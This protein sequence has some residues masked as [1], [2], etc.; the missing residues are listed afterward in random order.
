MN[1]L[2]LEHLAAV[3]KIAACRQAREHQEG[4]KLGYNQ[5]SA[6]SD[7]IK[8][9]SPGIPIETN[10]VSIEFFGNSFGSNNYDRSFIFNNSRATLFQAY[11]EKIGQNGVLNAFYNSSVN[12]PRIGYSAL[13]PNER[14]HFVWTREGTT[15]RAYING[16]LMGS[17]E[18]IPIADFGEF[19]LGIMNSSDV[20]F[21]RVWSYALSA[22]E[23]ATL[24]NNGNPA[25]YVLPAEM[26]SVGCVVEYLPQNLVADNNGLVSFWLDSA[27]QL[28]LNDEYLPPLLESTGGYDM[29]AK[30]TPEVIYKPK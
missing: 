19:H 24:Y 5:A 11:A 12:R 30:G 17:I 16:N 18:N 3:S 21:A 6:A 29:V 2:L 26:K 8:M 7:A 23:V 1:T 28:P 20:G 27:K 14:F 25:G 9:V 22:E 10:D 13:T 4:V 15:L